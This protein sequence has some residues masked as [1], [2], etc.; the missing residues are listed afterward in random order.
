MAKIIEFPTEWQNQE[1]KLFTGDG[2][3][4]DTWHFV[5]EADAVNLDTPNYYDLTRQ[6]L[7]PLD[8]WLSL[9]PV[10]RPSGFWLRSN[11]DIS[12]LELDLTH[13]QII[14]IA[15]PRSVDGRGYSIARILREEYG[16]TG[17][18][19]AI[20]EVRIDQLTNMNQVGFT[21]FALHPD[22]SI[23]SAKQALNSLPNR[24]LDYQDAKK[25]NQFNY[26]HTA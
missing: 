22:A 24:Y 18:I 6:I 11:D 20:G 9:S 10:N 26:R 7:F 25:G 3:I 15:F 4:S 19:R 21:E 13:T 12:K 16:F 14:A 1:T 8:A 2:V 5:S 23:E 17:I